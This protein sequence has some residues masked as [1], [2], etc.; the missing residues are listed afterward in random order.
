VARIVQVGWPDA[1]I[2]QLVL[3]VVNSEWGDGDWSEHLD[4]MLVSL[5]RQSD[6]FSA[7]SDHGF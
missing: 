3:P 6:G 1:D 5:S 2:R 4:S 7:F